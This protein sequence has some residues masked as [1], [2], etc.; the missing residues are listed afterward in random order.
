LRDDLRSLAVVFFKALWIYSLILWGF[1]VLFFFVYP[2]DQYD[3]LSI[4][5]PIPQNLLAILAFPVS[6]V[7]FIIW[8]YLKKT[9][10]KGP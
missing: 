1:I 5:V 8:E 9:R 10:G 3:Q 7:S 2:T 4:Y 6:F